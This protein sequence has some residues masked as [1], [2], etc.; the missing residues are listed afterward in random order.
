MKNHQVITRSAEKKKE[1]DEPIDLLFVR[2]F[3]YN[4]RLFTHPQ[5]LLELLIQRFHLPP[6]DTDDWTNQVQI[7][8]RLRVYNV[9]KTWLENYFMLD[10]DAVI[11]TRLLCFTQ[12]DLTEAMP[13]PAERMLQL[14]HKTV[15][16]PSVMPSSRSCFF[17][18][19][20]RRP[21]AR[22]RPCP[23]N[24]ASITARSFPTSLSL[25]TTP[26]IPPVS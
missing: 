5:E 8:V 25:T 9:I 11:H 26:S 2:A 12:T 19:Q 20:P 7:P 22:H 4:F 14:I 18:S 10:Q 17:S 16:R 23:K 6:T 1:T 21:H 15:S 3:F 13:T 24:P